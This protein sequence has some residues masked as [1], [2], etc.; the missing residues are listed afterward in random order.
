MNAD[1]T[2]LE[3]RVLDRLKPKHAFGFPPAVVLNDLRDLGD[4]RDLRQAIATLL[5]RQEIRFLRTVPGVWWRPMWSPLADMPLHP[6]NAMLAGAV[7][8]KLGQTPVV[9]VREAEGI[10]GLAERY[11]TPGAP[12]LVAVPGLDRD[13]RYGVRGGR[14][15][16]LA[17]PLPSWI[18]ELGDGV[19]QAVIQAFRR[20]LDLDQASLE[21]LARSAARRVKPDDFL[22]A[23]I[24][25]LSEIPPPFCAL[26]QVMCKEAELVRDR[27]IV[28]PE[29]S[30]PAGWQPPMDD[31]SGATVFGD[32]YVEEVGIDGVR[33]HRL[34]GGRLEGHPFLVSPTPWWHS[35]PLVWIDRRRG[36]ARTN[37]RLYRLIGPGADDGDW[38]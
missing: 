32:W 10:F 4:E 30:A 27:A 24:P 29:R 31:W 7:A 2:D 22:T 8:R 1:Y 16:V 37:S 17:E 35:S 5:R 15:I 6:T 11:D 13:L 18:A 9:S 23:V 33:Y 25:K 12:G 34:T 38:S 3:S 28:L 19:V 26:A 21:R 14:T 36:W 20:H